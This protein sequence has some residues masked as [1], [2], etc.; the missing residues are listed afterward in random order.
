ML[1]YFRGWKKVAA[2]RI[3]AAVDVGSNA[4]SESLVRAGSGFFC[5]FAP[6][7]TFGGALGGRLADQLGD[8]DGSD[9]LLHAMVI[10][11]NAGAF[12]VGLGDDTGAVLIMTNGLSLDENLQRALL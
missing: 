9:E 8:P 11:V 7:A 3:S 2:E 10:E 12:G 4:R 1:G 6:A 5:G